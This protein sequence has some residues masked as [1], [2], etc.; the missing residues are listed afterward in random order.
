[1][2]KYLYQD[3]KDASPVGCGLDNEINLEKSGFL[4]CLFCHIDVPFS[5]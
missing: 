2:L 4:F 1:L 3:M 5:L